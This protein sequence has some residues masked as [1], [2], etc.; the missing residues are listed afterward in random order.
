[1][2]LPQRAGSTN[3][4]VRWFMGLAIVATL[5]VPRVGSAQEAELLELTPMS[6]ELE[7]GSSYEFERGTLLVPQNR[8]H[9][10]GPFF[11]LEFYRFPA[12]EGADPSTPP[13]FHLNGGPG[14][15]GLGNRPQQASFLESEVFPRA[16]H[17]DLV[18]VGQRGIGS[19]AP[20]T[21]C[22]GARPPRA[23]DPFIVDERMAMLIEAARTC[24]ERWEQEGVDLEGIT[25]I[26]AA[27]DV[28]DVAAELG[29]DQIQIHGGSFGS[30]WGMTVIRYHPEL[31]ARALL[32]GMEG[33]DH[34]YDMPGWILMALERMAADA[35]AS[36]AFDGRLPDGGLLAGFQRVIAEAEAAPLRMQ[37]IRGA[38]RD[39]LF[40]EVTADE[41]RGLWGGYTNQ[42]GGHRV[43]GWASDMIR[44][45]EGDYTDAITA[46]VRNRFG[47]AGLPTAAFFMLDCGSG[48]SGIRLEQ[49]LSDPGAEVVGQLGRFYETLCSVWDADLGE[50][51]RQNFDTEVPT[52]I[53]HGNWDLSTPLENALELRPHF[54]NHRFVLVER[55]THGA[56]GEALRFSADFRAALDAY[57][58]TGDMSAFPETVTLPPV[59]W[60]PAPDR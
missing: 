59:E 43:R 37:N 36:G 25:V 60:V 14:W 30:H 23:G 40:L 15:P 1:M 44:L 56:I 21:A 17:A 32:N 20:N 50:G 46:V 26:E 24:R 8:E 35:E 28:R 55:G 42:Q 53:V 12:L 10:E 16:R 33:P 51:F 54:R 7:D 47:T 13:I 5:A 2:T 6:T 19:S 38:G 49:L 11:E 52:V 9:P 48:I 41:V 39:T 58:A 31:V 29:Y 18:F 22:R 57:M 27:N 45:A 4:T 3:L 34:T